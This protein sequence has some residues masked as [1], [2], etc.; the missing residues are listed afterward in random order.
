MNVRTSSLKRTL[1]II[2]TNLDFLDARKQRAVFKFEQC[3]DRPMIV[4]NHAK[5]RDDRCVS[6]AEGSATAVVS[7]AITEMHAGHAIVMP[8]HEAQ[9]ILVRSCKVTNIERGFEIGR[10]GQ[11][12]D[13]A[14]LSAECIRV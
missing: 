2:E 3:D 1:A 9:A 4:T 14:F 8:F 11:A 7:P 13:D 6:L 10:E 5:E 12:L